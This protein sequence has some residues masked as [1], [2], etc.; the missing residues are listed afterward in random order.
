MLQH[1]WPLKACYMKDARYKW[2]HIVWFYVYEMF[3][4]GKS[5]EIESRLVVVPGW[6]VCWR[7]GRWSD[8]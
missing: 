6:V 5:L 7:L 2:P 3:A 1:G 8:C 4:I